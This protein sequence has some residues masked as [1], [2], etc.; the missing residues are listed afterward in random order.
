MLARRWRLVERLLSMT[1]DT[2]VG[3]LRI[4]WVTP[5]SS[6]SFGCALRASLRM[7]VLFGG[8]RFRGEP[9]FLL[10][11]GFVGVEFVFVEEGEAYVVETV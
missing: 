2:A 6:G 8:Q 4:V 5:G 3:K 7:T 9:E 11:F 10:V 1:G